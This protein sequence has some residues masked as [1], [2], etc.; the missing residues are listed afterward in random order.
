MPSLLIVTAAFPPSRL[1]GSRR[2]LRMALGLAARGWTVCVLTLEDRYMRPVDDRGPDPEGIEVVRT[3]A[4][5]LR[6]WL[7]RPTAKQNVAATPKHQGPSSS[8]RAIAGRVLQRTEFPDAYAGWMP[9]AWAA[10]R[11][12]RFDLVLAT[13]PPPS[14][15]LL[16]AFIARQTDARLVLDY[17]DPWSEVLTPDGSYGAER[18]VPAAEIALH[19]GLED[20]VLRHADLV[21]AVTPRIRQWLAARTPRPVEFLPNG[22]DEVPADPP[23]P[24]LEPARLVYAGSLAYERSLQPVLT[25]LALLRDRFGPDQLRLTYAGPDGARLRR[26]AS[27][28]GVADWLDDFGELPAAQ[29]R[30][31]Y[32]GAT[33][34]IVSV[35]ARTDYSYPGKLFEV[36]GAGCPIWLCGPEQCDAAQLVRDLNAGEVDTGSSPEHS[37]A[38]LTRL[39]CAPPTAVQG[40]QPWLASNQMSRLD[41]LLRGVLT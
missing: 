32:R 13:L 38:V 25:A 17:R 11:H 5:M 7:P 31:L 30:S 14:A 36:L 4:A 40:L 12:R 29:A 26:E 41:R 16:G 21:L 22:L 34:G 27:Q 23:L 35:S 9:F 1:I 15:A 2:P 28:A 18:A 37:A 20:R 3:H 8:L 39:L 19:R 24:R 6:S 33:A 10:M